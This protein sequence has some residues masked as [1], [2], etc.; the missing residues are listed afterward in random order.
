M[1]VFIYKFALISIKDLKGPTE[2]CWCSVLVS[3]A[4]KTLWLNVVI[5]VWNTDTHLWDLQ[6]MSLSQEE[7]WVEPDLGAGFWV[8]EEPKLLTLLFTL[9]KS[10]L[11]NSIKSATI[12]LTCELN[13]WTSEILFG[14]VLL[15]Y[16]SAHFLKTW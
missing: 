13:L 11:I 8:L 15:F 6:G 4:T 12:Q 5:H 3:I 14:T 2:R 9:Y 7:K 1:L 10:A 16:P